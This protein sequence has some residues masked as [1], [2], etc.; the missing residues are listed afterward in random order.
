MPEEV[1]QRLTSDPSKKLFA[2]SWN[3]IKY[4][5]RDVFTKVENVLGS[6]KTKD[7]VYGLSGNVGGGVELVP[8]LEMLEFS[9]L[10]KGN[11]LV[12]YKK[13]PLLDD[14]AIILVFNAKNI[15]VSAMM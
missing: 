1:L 14:G 10:A 6:R 5:K 2:K 12:V 3:E 4:A 7:R 8:L 13:G 15:P 9:V 11:R